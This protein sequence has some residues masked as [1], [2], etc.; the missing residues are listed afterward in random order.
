VKH[1]VSVLLCLQLYVAGVAQ[2]TAKPVVGV[3]SF[4]TEVDSKYAQSVA[5]K[6]VEV[7]TNSRR[8]T[9]VDR[10]SYEK[11]EAELEFQKSEHFLNSQTVRQET[12][13][14]AQFLIVGHVVKMSVYAMKNA[15]G[16]TNGYKASAAFT[17]K[18]N[19]V[20]TGK[21]TEAENFQT[22]VS[23]LMLSPESAVNEALH[24]VEPQLSEYFRHT[25]P[26]RSQVG[27][28]LTTR[29]ESAQTILV[30]AGRSSGLAEGDILMVEYL[31]QIGGK[32]YPTKIGEARV[33]RVANDDFS[34][35][36]VL[37][38]GKEILIRFNAAYPIQC[39]LKTK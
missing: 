15:D 1:L 35:C 28:I 19:D 24:S 8:F 30:L 32:P 11:V 22:T 31:E 17:L 29:K 26:L 13:L 9:V 36:E 23:P 18:V 12:A 25:F 6:V 39:T 27:K 7:V 4:T 10:T 34:E 2:E 5:E 37:A 38:G 21:T 20:E 33:V 16:S 14:A 3:S